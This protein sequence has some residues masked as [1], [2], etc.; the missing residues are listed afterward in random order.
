MGTASSENRHD[1]GHV[2]RYFYIKPLCYNHVD[3]LGESC[4]HIINNLEINSIF[5]QNQK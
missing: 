5:I 4:D 3:L 2:L 1:K